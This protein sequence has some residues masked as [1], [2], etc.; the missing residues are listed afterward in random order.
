MDYSKPISKAKLKQYVSL[1]Q[2][3][4]RVQERLFIAEGERTVMQLLAQPKLKAEAVIIHS[5]AEASPDFWSLCDT[6]GADVYR[7][8]K[9]DLKALSDTQNMQ[10][11]IAVLEIPPP[12]NP[13]LWQPEPGAFILA[14]DGLSDPGNLGTIYRTAAWFGVTGILLGEGSVD[15]YNPKV[16]RSM[17]GATGSLP[18]A[19]CAL[20]DVL[21]EYQS[22]DYLIMLLDLNETAITLEKAAELKQKS[23]KPFVVVVGNEAHGISEALSSVYQAVYIPGNSDKVESLNAA[24]SAGIALSS[25]SGNGGKATEK[26]PLKQG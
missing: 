4:Y 9:R 8:G 2:K 16:V 18:S 20:P 22:R 3:K 24:V 6:A 17:A 23:K 26:P 15:L 19:E 13:L 25:L 10:G 11:M 5:E 12:Q 1:K 7:A 14:L 21:N